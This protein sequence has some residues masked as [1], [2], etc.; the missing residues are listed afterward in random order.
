MSY[1]GIGRS[2]AKFRLSFFG[3]LDV[4]ALVS[5]VGRG[6]LSTMSVVSRFVLEG[7]GQGPGHDLNRC[8]RASPER[9]G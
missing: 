2:S 3:L 7:T 4:L 8:W 9:K 1:L 5:S 6:V